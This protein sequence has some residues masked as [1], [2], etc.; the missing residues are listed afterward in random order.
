MIPTTGLPTNSTSFRGI[1]A[2]LH[3]H[4]LEDSLQVEEHDEQYPIP[5]PCSTLDLDLMD[6]V[7]FTITAVTRTLQSI[8]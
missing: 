7:F 8:S 5:V 4:G 3:G 2:H 1:H 6:I